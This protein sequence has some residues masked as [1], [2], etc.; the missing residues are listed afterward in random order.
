[1][2]DFIVAAR[3]IL[4]AGATALAPGARFP[5]TDNINRTRQLYE[6]RKIFVAPALRKEH[7]DAVGI[8]PPAV[9]VRTPVTARAHKPPVSQ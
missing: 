1:M 5:A 3:P 4:W 2:P 9:P 6:Q 7:P 8:L